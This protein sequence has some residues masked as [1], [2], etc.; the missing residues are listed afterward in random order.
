MTGKGRRSCKRRDE[1]SRSRR[2]DYFAVV[3]LQ[4]TF[5]RLP[6][7]ETVC[8][9]RQEA[10]PN[11]IF[12]LKAWQLITHEP[13]SPTYRKA[14][15]RIDP[16]QRDQYGRFRPTSQV[17]EAWKKTEDIA[18]VA[19]ATVVL[20][21]C[22]A[23]F[24]PVDENIANLRDFFSSMGKRKFQCAWE[25]RGPWPEDTIRELCRELELIHCVDP[26]V[27]DQLWGEVGYF[28]LHGLGG[29]G[30]RYTDGDLQRLRERISPHEDS[31][32]FF[33]NVSMYEDALRFKRM[34]PH[35]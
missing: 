27:S 3:E 23:S 6:R 5:Y 19:G 11:F 29:Y 7:I 34:L 14:G 31:Y 30:Y 28:R 25:P 20:F 32:L 21:Q 12:T 10:P 35:E 16:D 18:R 17:W 33:N 24:T 4:R 1:R 13:S 8:R 15:M 26:L 22:P 2:R 9:W